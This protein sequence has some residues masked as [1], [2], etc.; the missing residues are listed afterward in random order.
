MEEVTGGA[1]E[2]FVETSQKEDAEMEND[3]CNTDRVEDKSEEGTEVSNEALCNDNPGSDAPEED[4]VNPSEN[5]V[6]A[7]QVDHL[8]EAEKNPGD[9]EKIVRP[10]NSVT[11]AKP[12]LPATRAPGARPRR[13]SPGKKYNTAQTSS[14]SGIARQEAVAPREGRQEAVAPRE[15]RQEAVAPREG[16]QGRQVQRTRAA[17][18]NEHSYGTKRDSSPETDVDGGGEEEE[19]DEKLD[20]PYSSIRWRVMVVCVCVLIF[21]V[22]L[23]PWRSKIITK[24]I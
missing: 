2:A 10:S 3:T 21:Y 24:I 16:R 11:T 15:G 6:G 5:S 8:A 18:S 4:N 23:D 9:L 22:G 20:H 13:A 1:R 19:E 12:A 17:V 7:F 14:S